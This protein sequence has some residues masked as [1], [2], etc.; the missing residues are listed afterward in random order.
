[1]TFQVLIINLDKDTE[2]WKLVQE[3]CKQIGLKP[4]RIPAV[5]GAKLSNTQLKAETSHF[6]YNFCTPSMIGCWLSHKKCWQYVL[7]NNIDIAMILEDDAI[8]VDNFN[9][10]LKNRIKD[11]PTDWDILLLGTVLCCSPNKCNFL[12]N[13]ADKMKSLYI[14][15]DVEKQSISPHIYRPNVFTG[16][17]AY[18]INKKGAQ[19]CLKYLPLADGHVDVGMAS[20][21]QNINIYALTPSLA[22]Q[23]AEASNTTQHKN[24]PKLLNTIA[25]TVKSDNTGLGFVMTSPLFQIKGYLINLW[26]IFFL[27]YGI[28]L[29]LHKKIL[30][31][32]IISLLLLFSIEF[33]LKKDWQVATQIIGS[34]IM[35]FIGYI[36]GS[37]FH[38]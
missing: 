4:I 25:D 19:K 1:M 3:E 37:F 16:T 36:I 18:L 9:E 6:C 28:I 33:I 5:F 24:F 30:I 35:V 20:K 8:F 32:G 14:M 13:I 11:V 26:C 29:S 23:K 12:A 38:K 10:L 34:S 17:H 15:S 27:L 2:R 7:D 31:V 21:A 22:I